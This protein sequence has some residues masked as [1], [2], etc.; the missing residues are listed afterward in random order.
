MLSR[1]RLVRGLCGL[2]L[3]VPAV[4]VWASPDDGQ[5]P[6]A[7][8]PAINLETSPST[9]PTGGSQPSLGSQPTESVQPSTGSQPTESVQPSPSS[10]PT[11]AIQPSAGYQ[12]TV[13]VQSSSG[14]LPFSSVPSVEDK[15]TPPKHHHKGLLGWRHCVECQRARA[16]ARDG[17]D[18]PPPPSQPGMVYQGQTIVSG[19]MV[20]G[21]P[22]GMVVNESPAGYA[23]VGPGGPQDEAGYAVVG[24]PAPSTEPTPIG[25]ARGAQN[26]WADPRMAAMAPRPGAAGPYDPSV[27]PSSLPPAQSAMASPGHDRPHVISH[28]LGLDVFSRHREARHEKAREKHAAI[29]YGDPNQKVTELPASMV[30]GKGG[31]R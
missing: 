7:A 18:V 12:P 21:D 2:V 4:P 13:G 29:A 1:S 24:G 25:L 3:A 26:P 16:K 14:Y 9:E 10:L 27:V 5:A 8:S 17:I 20:T 22:H 6:A 31:V 15:P 23:V 30:Y 19:P 11:A 28:I